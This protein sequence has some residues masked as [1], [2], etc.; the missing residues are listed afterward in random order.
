MIDD[1]SGRTCS[2]YIENLPVPQTDEDCIVNLVYLYDFTNIGTLL[3]DEVEL[4]TVEMDGQSPKVFTPALTPD[5]REFCPGDQLTIPDPVPGSNICSLAGREV[6]FDVELNDLP[7]SGSSIFPPLPIAVCGEN[8]ERTPTTPTEMTFVVND[9]CICKIDSAVDGTSSAAVGCEGSVTTSV[10]PPSLRHLRDNQT[11][12]MNNDNGNND[13]NGNDNDNDNNLNKNNNQRK[14]NTKRNNSKGNKNNGN[15]KNKVQGKGG[16]GK[17]SI[18]ITCQTWIEI[19]S[20]DQI[21]IHSGYHEGGDEISMS[22]N[23]TLDRMTVD[24]YHLNN[25]ESPSEPV[26]SFTID[27]TCVEA[28]DMFGCLELN[29]ITNYGG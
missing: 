21:L 9:E 26:E 29:R 23:P 13:S 1:T 12:K 16:K 15:N 14:A 24:I 2:E 17:G 25:G 10:I 4:F 20:T 27:P 6:A 8:G 18:N 5:E 3:C 11:N 28:G 19:R 7:A 22:R